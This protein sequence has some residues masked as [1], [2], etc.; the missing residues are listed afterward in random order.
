VD[1]E[2]ARIS[3]ERD[4]ERGIGEGAVQMELPFITSQDLGIVRHARGTRFWKK[5]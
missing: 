4:R 1:R 2:K 3:T 5:T